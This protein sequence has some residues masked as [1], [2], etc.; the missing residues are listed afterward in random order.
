MD[1]LNNYIRFSELVKGFSA[2]SSGKSPPYPAG[3][4]DVGK[5]VFVILSERQR[6]EGS[7]T[8]K[9]VLWTMA[10]ISR[11]RFAPLE[12]TKGNFVQNDKGRFDRN[13]KVCSD[14]NDR[15]SYTL[16]RKCMISPSW[17]T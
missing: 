11:L 2:K 14:R 12:M 5:A 10:E 8:L 13:D 15:K 3:F 16:N 17:T 7:Q 9:S 6:V 4:Y 1:R